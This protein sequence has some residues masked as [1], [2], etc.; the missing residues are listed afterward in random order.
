MAFGSLAGFPLGIGILSV[1]YL[2]LREIRK[3]ING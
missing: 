1:M 3:K 2:V